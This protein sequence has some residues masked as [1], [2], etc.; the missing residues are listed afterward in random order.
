M[1]DRFRKDI[2]SEPDS[3]EVWITLAVS[4]LVSK[5]RKVGEVRFHVSVNDDAV[6]WEFW[7]MR[8]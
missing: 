3:W 8:V 6:A 1:G 2:N 7:G 5:V 4:A